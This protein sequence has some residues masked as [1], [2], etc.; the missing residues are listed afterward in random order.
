VS[1]VRQSR[2]VRALIGSARATLD[3]S[4][5]YRCNSGGRRHSLDS[6]SVKKLVSDG[7][8]KLVRGKCLATPLARNWLQRRLCAGGEIASQ[9][10]QV[11][12]APDQTSINLGESVV[13][14]LAVSRNGGTPF[15]QA[16]HVQSA[17]RLRSL[18][19]RARLIG[20]TTMSYDPTRTPGGAGGGGAPFD[21]GAV[22]VDARAELR[23]I[24]DPLPTDCAGVLIDVCGFLKGLQTIEFERKWPRRSAKLVLRI[25]LD[26]LALNF[27]LS[28]LA[29]GIKSTRP[30]FWM[31]EGA[32]PHSL[33]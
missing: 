26:Q 5:L 33:E 17:E 19:E 15:L 10:R 29:T 23:R 32:R 24:L 2:F 7:V 27:G 8:L 9:H 22:G 21:F 6:D 14:T 31:D 16:H 1:S 20:R 12:R 3:D 4:G 18:V 25:G 28:P 11:V 30:R 13:A